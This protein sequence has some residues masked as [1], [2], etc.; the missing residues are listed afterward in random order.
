MKNI[1]VAAFVAA[2]LVSASTN[3]SAISISTASVNN[4]Y[5]YDFGFCGGDAPDPLACPGG[6]PNSFA[7]VGATVAFRVD[8]Y[9]YNACTNLTSVGFTVALR[10]D[11]VAPNSS[12]ISVFG[13]ATNPDIVLSASDAT[14]AFD[15]INQDGFPQPNITNVEVCALD[16]QNAECNN[17]N[18]GPT[19]GQTIF[20]TMV[21]GFSGP[22]TS[23]DMTDFAVRYQSVVIPGSNITSGVG[24]GTP[25]PPGTPTPFDVVPEPTSMVLVGLGLLGAGIARRRK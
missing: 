1:A 2:A 11:T 22:L 18:G 6:V 5:A 8:S 14:G 24:L 7:G 10:N 19:N 9:S 23:I 21:L 3:A 20:F 16:E 13:F 12:R 17:G 4:V 25:L 15:D